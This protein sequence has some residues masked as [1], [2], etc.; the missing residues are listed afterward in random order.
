MQNCANVSVNTFG[1]MA[2]PAKLLHQLG[3]L[4]FG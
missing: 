1:E 2:L 4:G 3:Q